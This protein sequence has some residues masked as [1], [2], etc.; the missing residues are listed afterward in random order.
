MQI[1]L[2]NLQREV[3]I[4]FI[5]VTHDQ[6]E[7]LT[8]SDRIAVMNKGLALQVGEAE[9]IYERP[10]S[11][12][13]ADFIGETNFIE[14]T[15]ADQQGGVVEVELPGAGLARIQSTRTFT[16]GTPVSIAIRPEKL[17]LNAPIEGGN[18]LQGSA[19]EIIYIGTDTQYN[20]RLTDGQKVR[21]RQQNATRAHKTLCAW[22][23]AVTVSFTATAPRLLT[24]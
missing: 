11:K 4:T 2:K 22:G 16:R 14:G 10:A 3:G 20:I 17:R 21:V 12:F 18:N 9:E 15:V 24:E 13:V 1:E 8:M 19:M 5:Y 6:E 7:A 23:D